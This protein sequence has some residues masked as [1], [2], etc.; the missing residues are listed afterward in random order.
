MVFIL[1]YLSY[2]LLGLRPYFRLKVLMLMRPLSL[3]TFLLWFI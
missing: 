3:A 1:S 2:N